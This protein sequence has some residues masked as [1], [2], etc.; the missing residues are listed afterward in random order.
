LSS[1]EQLRVDFQ[2]AQRYL[3]SGENEAKLDIRFDATSKRSF[4][5]T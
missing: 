1:T 5:G 4:T 3:P 2:L